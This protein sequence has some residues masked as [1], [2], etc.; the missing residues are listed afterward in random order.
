MKKLEGS[1]K[2]AANSARIPS[3]SAGVKTIMSNPPKKQSSLVVS[4]RDIGVQFRDND[5]HITGHDGCTSQLL[6]DG[7]AIWVYG[8]TVIQ[9]FDDIH[10]VDIGTMLTG[11]A[12]IVPPQDVSRGIKEYS[13]LK[14]AD[15]S[16]RT[17]VD[18]TPDEDP[19]LRRLWAIHG[20]CIG[21]SMYLYYHTIK[22][23]YEKNVF[24]SFA[25][26]GMGIARARIG[27][28][29]FER[30]KAPDGTLHF[31]KAEE[32][33]F[34]VWVLKPEALGPD[35]RNKGH[36]YL[37]GTYR[38]LEGGSDSGGQTCLARVPVD[39]VED[40]SAYEYLVEAPTLGQ[41]E[42]KVRWDKVFRP[43]AFLFSGAPNEMSI[44]YNAHLGQYVALHMMGVQNQ[45]AIRS[46]PALTGPWSEAQIFH[47]PEKLKD[48]DTYYALKEHPELASDGGRII[49]ATYVD[50]GDYMP[51]L[52]EIRLS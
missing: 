5:V 21:G 18:F 38:P 35:L 29:C 25:L 11:S 12:C 47:R 26:E 30:L 14:K 3:F 50:T 9:K 8:D 34:G 45:C 6:P 32:P 7:R 44:S 2:A 4:I 20:A 27:D 46:A 42:K 16:A 37:C 15:G 51:R 36:M 49:Y 28:F 48:K 13:Y 22:L 10:K 39:R 24:E 23:S 33:T 40:L 19:R 1:A 41:P 17:P 31:W 43:G 52:L